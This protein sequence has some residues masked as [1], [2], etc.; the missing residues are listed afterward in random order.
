MKKIFALLLSLVTLC[1]LM[2]AAGC[3]GSEK[4]A[5]APRRSPSKNCA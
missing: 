3:G 2:L 4:K 1:A 5:E